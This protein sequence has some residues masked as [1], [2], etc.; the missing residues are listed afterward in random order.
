MKRSLLILALFAATLAWAQPKTV[1]EYQE[2]GVTVGKAGGTLRL[3]L[4]A[5]PQSFFYYGAIDSSLQT[6]AEQLFDG[7]VEYNYQTYQ[8]EPALAKS[9]ELSDD[10]LT[11][12]FHL[13]AGVKWHDGEPFTADDVV[14][15]FSNL[16]ANPEA[17]GGD[18]GSFT[19]E[20]QPVKFVKVDDLTVQ[21][22]LPKPQPAI[23]QYARVPVLPK[24]KLLSY[25][26]EGGAPPARINEAWPTDTDPAQI[27]GTGPFKLA[28]YTPG[29]QV[30]LE[31][32]PDY[33][34]VDSAGNPLPYLDRLELVI[35]SDPSAQIAQFL[36][37]N[38]H[39]INVT[40][41]QFPDLKSREVAGANF[42]VVQAQTLFGSA[43][44]L[45]FNF[46]APNPELAALFSD[47]RFRKA[48]DQALDRAK[49]I[50]AVYNGLAELPGHGVAPVSE[51]YQ[52]TRAYLGPY[53]PQAA[54][55]TLDDMGLKAGPDGIR[56]LAS[57]KP[58]AFTLTYATDSETSPQIA[59]ILQNDLRALG[60]QVHLQGI[61]NNV[62]LTTALGGKLEA[63][64]LSFGDQPDPELRAPIW[65]P[66]GSLYYWH[67]KTQ[68]EPGQDPNFEAMQPFEREIYQIWQQAGAETNPERRRELYQN[69][70]QLAAENRLVLMI[71]KPMGIGAVANGLENYIY[72]L[73]V[74]PGYNPVPLMYWK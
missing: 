33:W 60:V 38:L 32:N 71:A 50:D 47:L 41:A 3:S 46:D 52:D 22:V 25:S 64:L 45:A 27:V 49:I 42:R 10:G 56:K 43:P 58:L 20:G 19:I 12:T 62:L 68:S 14:F 8:L 5:A 16:V 29:Q 59:T 31:K 54:A 11:Y 53:D 61:L 70:Q 13:R 21:F 67:P 39:Q 37:G 36:A 17:R 24:H 35:V 7:L 34:K 65:K 63:V 1:A 2:L 66:G 57:G 73:G 72:N 69:W 23:L 9:W 4:P 55:Q 28:R 15:T 6:V 18:A 40:G 48:I 30:S 51:W 44:H 26:V 74:I